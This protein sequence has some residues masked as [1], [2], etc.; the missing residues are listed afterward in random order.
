MVDTTLIGILIDGAGFQVLPFTTVA[1][2]I[3]L[4]GNRV[5]RRSVT[6]QARNV[7]CG[8]GV[9]QECGVTIDGHAHVLGCQTLCCEGMLI[10]TAS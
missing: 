9:C 2:A 3:A 4:H 10:E 6:G 5:S 8:M 1:A 7:L